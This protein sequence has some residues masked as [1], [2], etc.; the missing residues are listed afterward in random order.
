MLRVPFSVVGPLIIVVC[1]IGAYTVAN[2][3][4]DVC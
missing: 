2:S 3:C 1:L 4:L